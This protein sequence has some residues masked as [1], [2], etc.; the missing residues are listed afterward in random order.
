MVL[1]KCCDAEIKFWM[2]PDSV[3]HGLHEETISPKTLPDHVLKTD[4]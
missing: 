3:G 4:P 1:T 2:V